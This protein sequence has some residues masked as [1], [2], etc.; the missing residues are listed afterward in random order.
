MKSTQGFPKYKGL[1]YNKY[2]KS[3]KLANGIKTSLATGRAVFG[4]GMVIIHEV[5]YLHTY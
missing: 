1:K 4:V 2:Q 3:N 5:I